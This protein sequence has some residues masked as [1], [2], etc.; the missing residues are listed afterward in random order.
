MILPPPTS[1]RTYTLFPATTLF[2]SNLHRRVE[3]FLH[4]RIQPVDLVDEKDVV[5]L[6][7]GQQRRQI[8]RLRDHRPGCGAKVDAKLA[9][10][11]LRQS[12]LAKAGRAEEPDMVQRIAPAARRL[13]EPHHNDPK[14]LG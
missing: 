1:T 4:R 2:R 12:G 7:I 14:T 5:R 11:D 8:A 10:D 3:H 9:R 6:E 13:A